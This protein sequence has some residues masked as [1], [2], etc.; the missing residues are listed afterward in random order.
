MYKATAL[1]AAAPSWSV[2]CVDCLLVFRGSRWLPASC[3]SRFHAS[4]FPRFPALVFP[5]RPDSKILHDKT[6]WL[7]TAHRSLLPYDGSYKSATIRSCPDDS[8]HSSC[9]LHHVL[10]RLP[11]PPPLL[12]L[13]LPV[14][15]LAL[16]RAVL[17]EPHLAR[18]L[19]AARRLLFPLGPA[20]RN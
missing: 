1:L 3:C 14:S 5:R 6:S 20:I 16:V 8:H 11:P 17:P 13:L 2:M 9:M 18:R 19:L 4:S 10:F 12:P 15:L 7:P